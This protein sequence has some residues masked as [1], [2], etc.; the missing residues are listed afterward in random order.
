MVKERLDVFLEGIESG[1]EIQEDNLNEGVLERIKKSFNDALE[2]DAFQ[3]FMY[4]QTEAEMIEQLKTMD[5]DFVAFL[6]LSDPNKSGGMQKKQIIAAKNELKK[7][8]NPTGE[9]NL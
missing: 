7:R 3:K 5:N 8:M 6:A 2:S 4:N 1:E 9:S